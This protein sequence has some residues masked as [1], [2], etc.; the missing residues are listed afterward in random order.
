MAFVSW[1]WHLARMHQ[2]KNSE[3]DHRTCKTRAPLTSSVALLVYITYMFRLPARPN[4]LLHWAH[5]PWKRPFLSLS[6]S[7]GAEKHL[8]SIVS[9]LLSHFSDS[10]VQGELQVSSGKERRIFKALQIC[11][12]LPN[13]ISLP[14]LWVW[15]L[16]TIFGNWNLYHLC[17]V[18]SHPTRALLSGVKDAFFWC[19]TYECIL[20]YKWE[21]QQ[22]SIW[23]K[24][25]IRQ[26]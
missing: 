8:I 6:L 26:M 16:G 21:K 12:V 25:R 20:D 2:I 22:C 10:R 3:T 15:C 11:W 14:I 9:L 23:F 19:N 24:S 5:Y 18:C 4:D 17:P 1:G 13:V 7:Q